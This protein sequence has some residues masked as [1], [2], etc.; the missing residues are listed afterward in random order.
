MATKTK[1]KPAKKKVKKPKYSLEFRINDEVFK[2][3]DDNLADAFRTVIEDEK[4][5]VGPKTTTF[6]K[7]TKGKDE[8]SEIWH[9]PKARRTLRIAKVKETALD[10]L[11]SRFEQKLNG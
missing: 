1:S 9:V 5:P 7:V 11:A 6:V 2:A 4:F 3:A 10:I 8:Y